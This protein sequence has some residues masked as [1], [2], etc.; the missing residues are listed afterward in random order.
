MKVTSCHC[1]CHEGMDDIEHLG[2]RCYCHG[3]ADDEASSQ[4]EEDTDD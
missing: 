3:V 4:T 1:L 2:M